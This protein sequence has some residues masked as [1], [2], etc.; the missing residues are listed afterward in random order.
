MTDGHQP[1]AAHYVNSP[2]PGCQ[3]LMSPLGLFNLEISAG[4]D[5]G[6]GGWPRPTA[7]W[8]GPSCRDRPVYGTGTGWAGA[9]GWV[10]CRDYAIAGWSLFAL[11]PHVGEIAMVGGGGGVNK[12]FSSPVDCRAA[13][14]Y[15]WRHVCD[16]QTPARSLELLNAAFQQLRISSLSEGIKCSYQ[17]VSLVFFVCVFFFSPQG[18]EWERA[19]LSM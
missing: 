5:W 13:P 12:R 9:W 10:K 2:G 18:I 1:F 4:W 19:R 15:P 8:R 6:G 11:A 7:T 16:S 3:L 17:R 14:L